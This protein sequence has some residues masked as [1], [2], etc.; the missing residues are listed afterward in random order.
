MSL[1]L[2][3]TLTP[4]TVSQGNPDLK[5]RRSWNYDLSGE[6]YLGAGA[7]ISAAVF[8]KDIHDE[9]FTK[10]MVGTAVYTDGVTYGATIT[11]PVNAS[12]AAV[13]GA[14]LQIVKDRL[15]FLPGPLANFG[16]SLNATWLD[17][18][19]NFITTD[20]A[21]RRID[22]LFNQPGHIYNATLFYTDGPFTLR[23][24]Y[25]RIGAA[26]VS[27]DAR[28]SWR[29]IWQDSRDQFDLQASYN[30]KPWL[31]VMSQVQNV[32]NTAFEAHLGQN[33]E[34]LQT[35]YPVGRTIWFGLILKPRFKH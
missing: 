24:A 15:D 18:H 16:V 12:S 14:E 13:K 1:D 3:S 30:I 5:P 7:L 21:S 10:T 8:Y 19:F 11:Q 34:L 32:T 22:A 29:D 35:R 25:N 6:L 28:Y 4:L 9:I 27:V 23:A 20:G 2:S 17:G 31:Q 33:R 26:P